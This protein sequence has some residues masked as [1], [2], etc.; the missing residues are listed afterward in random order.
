MEIKGV[1]VQ[2]GSVEQITDTFSKQ[3]LIIDVSDNPQYP[4][5]VK[6]ELHK[7]KVSLSNNIKIGDVV[8]I[9][10]NMNGRE[11]TNKEGKK[12]YFTTLSIWKINV[13]N[14]ADVPQRFDSIENSSMPTHEDDLPF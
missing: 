9:H 7:D 4:S 8:E 11:W 3:D 14:S 5:P 1:V 12:V 2:I 13:L 6:F 10:F